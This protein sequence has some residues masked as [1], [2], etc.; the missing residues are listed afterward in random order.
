[1]L[2]ALRRPLIHLPVAAITTLIALAPRVFGATIS[3]EDA[4]ARALV[5]APSVASASAQSDLDNARIDEFRAPLFPSL[6]ANGEYQQTP[7]YD[8]V[9]TNR[10]LTLAQLGLDY[11]AFDGGRRSAQVRSAHY[12]ALA[13]ALGITAARN[14]T[15]FDT[16]VAYY[17]LARGRE[18]EAE[19]Q[20]SADRLTQYVKVIEALQRSGRAIDSDVL[21]LRTSYDSAMLTLAA[22]HQAA[23]HASIM[24][25]SMMGDFNDTALQVTDVP[26][27][28]PP[29]NGDGSQDP[30]YRAAT[31]QVQAAELAV[32]AARAERAP[33]FKIAVTTGWEGINP[34][35]TFNHYF[36]ASYDGALSVP[37]FDGGLIRSHINEAQAALHAA[38]AQHLQIDLQN[39]RDLADARSRYRDA[40]DQIALLRRSRQTAD[41]LFALAW[42]RFLGGGNIT[43][44]EVVSAYQQAESLRL[45]LFDQQFAA[46]QATAQVEAILG[47]T[48]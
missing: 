41:D 36:G 8:P 18:A 23:A 7:G 44:L 31:R 34:P 2:L 22:D 25:G 15:I 6:A 4:I 40:V 11:T 47:L 24:L 19:L 16:T 48:Q 20:A 3:L 38:L 32:D 9:V 46:R 12:A 33:T 39:R 5:F 45:A 26:A 21:M 30:A 37:I 43:L 14:Q 10:G 28:A 35:K 29:P 13:S 1:M 42:T 17:D 27:P